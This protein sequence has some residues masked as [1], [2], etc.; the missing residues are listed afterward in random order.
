MYLFI[1]LSV[2]MYIT[3]QLSGGNNMEG[4][5]LTNIIIIN[6]V[7]LIVAILFMLV[8]FY[9]TVNIK[10][11]NRRMENE[12]YEKLKP[13]VMDYINGKSDR[14]KNLMSSRLSKNTVLNIILDYSENGKID[15][16]EIIESLGLDSVLK[17]NL[18]KNDNK[19]LAIKNIGISN[20]NGAYDILKEYW[21]SDDFDERY[22]SMYC[23]IALLKKK[24]YT[25]EIIDTILGAGFSD[26]RKIEMIKILEIEND[27]IIDIINRKQSDTS[28]SVMLYS[29]D[30]NKL[31]ERQ[32]EKIKE[33]TRYNT[34]LEIGIVDSFLMSKSKNAFNHIESLVIEK[35][36]PILQAHIANRLAVYKSKKGFNLLKILLHSEDWDVKYNAAVAIL[37][38]GEEGRDYLKDEFEHDNISSAGEMANLRLNI[39]I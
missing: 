22:F 8:V 2:K 9:I 29:I 3:E 33:I 34:E 25:M 14:I 26:D 27:V 5:I 7:V 18:K 17:E 30:G 21:N 12:E 1:N 39:N 6:I 16:G 19:I 31:S 38:Y 37:S 13:D 15:C 24:K 28:K 23:T 20:I 10:K 36:D 32:I 4:K 35:R 11:R